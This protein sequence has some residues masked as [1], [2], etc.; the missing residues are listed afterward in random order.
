V[1]PLFYGLANGGAALVSS[2]YNVNF[3]L[4]V[5]AKTLDAANGANESFFLEA[6]ATNSTFAPGAGG[7]TASWAFLAIGRMVNQTWR[8]SRPGGAI[9]PA[10]AWT[11]VTTVSIL[12]VGGTVMSTLANTM[13]VG[14]LLSHIC[15]SVCLN[16]GSG[17]EAQ[18]PVR[19]SGAGTGG[20][21]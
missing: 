8:V 13:S 18:D 15:R 16:P 1:A 3:Q 2:V 20:T 12:N 14:T 10:D 7:V 5:A 9:V 6:T 19:Q 4:D 21:R 11:A 17:H